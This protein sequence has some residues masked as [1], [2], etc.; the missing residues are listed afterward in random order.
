MA[1]IAR[2]KKN[3]KSGGGTKPAAIF[4]SVEP[5]RAARHTLH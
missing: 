3:D 5:V 1:E 2:D 4:M